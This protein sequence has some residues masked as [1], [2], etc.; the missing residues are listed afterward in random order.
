MVDE[1]KP[2]TRADALAAGISSSALASARYRRVFRNV[3]VLAAVG[4][5]RRQR[6]EGALV[7]HPEGAW[8]SH[9]SAASLRGV[10]VPDD[11]H[12]HVSVVD[13]K[14][15]R[16]TPGLKPHVAPPGTEVVVVDGLRVSGVVRMFVELAAVLPLV[17]LVVAGDSMCRVLR[18]R[19]DWLRAELEKTR[20]YWSPAARYAAQFVRDRVD[21]PMETRLRML[22]V[23]AGFPEP[24]VNLE[25]RDH[26]GDVVLR[27]DLAYRRARVAV[28]YSG[29][30]HVEVIREWERDINRQDLVDDAEWRVV[31][32]VASGI[33]GD[34]RSTL[35][36]VARALRS[37]GVAVPRTYDPEWIRHF[38]GRP[39]AA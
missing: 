38:P 1:M 2:F 30:Q 39:R 26:D 12:V 5:E 17:D 32:V 35:D 16:W 33:Y 27:F 15:R 13:A 21:S 36:R 29:R 20:D 10:A 37:R 28:E 14:D 19:A 23:L 31:T 34:P 6:F 18:I 24:E 4:L 25:L 7:L 3:Y 22:L 11:P 8:L 9:T